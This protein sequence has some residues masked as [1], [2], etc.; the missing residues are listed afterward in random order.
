MQFQQNSDIVGQQRRSH[1]TRNSNQSQDIL[2]LDEENNKNNSNS[3]LHADLQNQKKGNQHRRHKSLHDIQGARAKKSFGGDDVQEK[4]QRQQVNNLNSLKKRI[5]EIREK[6]SDGE[7]IFLRKHQMIQ[8]SLESAMNK[9]DEDRQAQK[10]IKSLRQQEIAMLTQSVDD[11][12]DSEQPARKE[13]ER[14]LSEMI[15]VSCES[16]KQ[17]IIIE[18][19]DRFQ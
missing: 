12:F 6:V 19:R 14:Q 7:D 8:E 17:R 5:S 13:H 16:L 3:P 2:I 18:S 10:E 15:N 1:H 11:Y 9:I 4:W